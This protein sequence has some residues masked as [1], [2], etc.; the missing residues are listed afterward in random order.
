M[1]G[2]V[3]FE[4]NKKKTPRVAVLWQRTIDALRDFE[5]ASPN[6]SPF[7]FITRRKTP[8]SAETM[9]QWFQSLR[10]T[11]GVPHVQFS[12]IRDGAYT[13]AVNSPDTT[14]KACKLLAGH[15]CGESD[16]YARRNAEGVRKAV[17][18]I[19]RAYFGPIAPKLARNAG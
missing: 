10:E 17:E 3:L 8:Y 15:S 1:R 9:M 13:A 19:D 4:R 14:E 5:A 16:A 11:A 18:A 12:H 7:L 6:R 2:T